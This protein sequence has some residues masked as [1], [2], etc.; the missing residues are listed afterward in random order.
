MKR[1]LWILVLSLCF[2]GALTLAANAEQ[3]TATGKA[4]GQGEVAKL[5]QEV[6]SLHLQAEQIRTQLQ[7]LQAQAKPLREQLRSLREKIKVDREKIEH[8][9]QEHK[10]QQQQAT[11]PAVSPAQQK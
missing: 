4:E 5:R 3:P 2:A 6:Q 7:Q 1:K 10:G 8:L 11:A 9:R